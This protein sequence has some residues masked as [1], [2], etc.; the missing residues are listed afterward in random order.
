M[1]NKHLVPTRTATPVEQEEEREDTPPVEPTITPSIPTSKTMGGSYHFMQ[2]SE[3]EP[4]TPFDEGAEWVEHP[5]ASAILHN[6][7]EA[8][9]TEEDPAGKGHGALD[10]AAEDHQDELPPIAGLQEHFGTSGQATPIA[11][12][13]AAEFGND[14][15][16][17]V[18]DSGS[19]AVNEEEDGFTT[20]PNKRGG[21]GQGD[22][23][24]GDR[25]RGRGSFRGRGNGDWRS[26]SGGWE[27]KEGEGH[28]GGRGGYRGDNRGRGDIRGR[29]RSDWKPRGDYRGRGEGRGGE[30]LSLHV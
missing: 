4:Q 26:G 19:K 5:A 29:P 23:R 25:G 8:E 10:W 17:P 30:I 22:W 27:R 3:L 20:I 18:G 1:L 9:P 13:P 2:E 15:S 12:T 6:A 11:E 24:G 21:H 7:P 28:S 14:W 16:N